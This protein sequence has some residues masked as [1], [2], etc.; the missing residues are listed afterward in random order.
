MMFLECDGGNG[1]GRCVDKINFGSASD[2]CLVI[3]NFGCLLKLVA[4]TCMNSLIRKHRFVGLSCEDMD[5]CGL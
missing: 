5:R 3:G 1:P 4:L 2:F